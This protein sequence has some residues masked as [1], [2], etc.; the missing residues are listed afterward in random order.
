MRDAIAY[1]LKMSGLLYDNDHAHE[2]A[3]KV[4]LV[5]NMIKHDRRT[6]EEIISGDQDEENKEDN[7]NRSAQPYWNSQYT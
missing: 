6:G 5:L 3:E 1:V 2:L 4:R 7:Q